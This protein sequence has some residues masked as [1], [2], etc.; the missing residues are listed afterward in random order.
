[1]KIIICTIV[2]TRYDQP[3]ENPREQE[4]TF[5]ARARAHKNDPTLWNSIFIALVHMI[6]NY[7]APLACLLVCLILHFAYFDIPSPTHRLFFA[8]VVLSRLLFSETA[9]TTKNPT[10]SEKVKFFYQKVKEKNPICS[11]YGMTFAPSACECV[12]VCL[13]VCVPINLCRLYTTWY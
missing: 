10:T 5:I 4:I 3:N 9:T 11:T 1:M 12:L 13:C 6:M 2:E 7:A 8:A